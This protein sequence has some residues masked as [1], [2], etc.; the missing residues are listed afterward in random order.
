MSL[1]GEFAKQFSRHLDPLHNPP[2]NLAYMR[3][4][5]LLQAAFEREFCRL[6][7]DNVIWLGSNFASSNSDFFRN[8]ERREL[9][10]C[11]VSNMVGLRYDFKEGRR[12]FVS[13]KNLN[14]GA[15]HHLSC[16]KG[17]LCQMET[18]NLFKKFDG[19][20]TGKGIG[21]WLW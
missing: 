19:A 14:E 10:R 4:V 8:L 18:V 16:K 20:H 3:I 15:I 9:Y 1:Q 7:N 2:Q 5:R 6:V 13:K 12:L 21:E 17:V 11:I